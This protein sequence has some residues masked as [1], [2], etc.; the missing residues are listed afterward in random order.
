MALK[1]LEMVLA[2]KIQSSCWRDLQV[3]SH[4]DSR[5]AV[6]AL[7]IFRRIWGYLKNRI[8]TCRSS[9]TKELARSEVFVG[10]TWCLGLEFGKDWNLLL[11]L[12]DHSSWQVH[13][14]EESEKHEFQGNF[15]IYPFSLQFELIQMIRNKWKDL[16]RTSYLQVKKFFLNFQMPWEHKLNFLI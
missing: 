16:I 5:K 10:S 14:K 12:R 6:K 2:F 7:T 9:C 1:H 4:H 8:V 13:R 3:W 15:L 11:S